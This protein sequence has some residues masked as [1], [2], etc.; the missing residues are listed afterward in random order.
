MIYFL[1]E[2]FHKSLRD[3]LGKIIIDNMAD[4]KVHA[5]QQQG[6][7]EEIFECCIY[8]ITFIFPRFSHQCNGF[9]ESLNGYI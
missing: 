4:W 2:H 7:Q 8:R 6:K 9:S 5:M 3:L 1:K